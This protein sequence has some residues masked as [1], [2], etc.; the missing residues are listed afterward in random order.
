MP[1]EAPAAAFELYKALVSHDARERPTALDVIEC[2]EP[3]QPNFNHNSSLPLS[4]GTSLPGSLPSVDSRGNAQPW[5][6]HRRNI[7]G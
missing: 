3:L 7:S 4:A 2:L 5:A 1:D 6:S